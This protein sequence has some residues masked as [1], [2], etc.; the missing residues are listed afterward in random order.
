ML[1]PVQASASDPP[2]SAPALWDL[3]LRNVSLWSIQQVEFCSLQDQRLRRI[4]WI[5]PAMPADENCCWSLS[6]SLPN[7]DGGICELRASSA[8]PITNEG[9]FSALTTLLKT[10]VAHFAAHREQISGRCPLP[11][12]RL[13]AKDIP[14][15]IA[16]RPS[17]A[18]RFAHVMSVKPCLIL[19]S[20]SA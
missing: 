3:L 13:R 1:R 6:V 15:A 8:K 7:P 2:L 20:T 5:D 14:M 16:K 4:R 12:S 10:F 9:E 11:P 18:I 17:T 19:T